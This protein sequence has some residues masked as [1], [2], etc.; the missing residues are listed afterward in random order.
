M[1]DVIADIKFVV[2]L[3]DP[4]AERFE[5]ATVLGTD[6]A[7][8]VAPFPV[9]VHDVR[10]RLGTSEA[11]TLD[12]DGYAAEVMPYPE[13]NSGEE[14]WEDEYS[15]AMATWLQDYL[16]ARKVVWYNYHVRRRIPEDDPDH[17][18]EFNKDKL[19]PATVAHVDGSQKVAFERACKFLELTE[20]EGRKERL[21]VINLWRPLVGPV[22]DFPL[23]LCDTRTARLAD[24]EITTDVYGEGSF[25]RYSPKHSFHYL[26]DQMPD[27]MLLLRCFDSTRSPDQSGV[28]I[29]TAFEDKARSGP[30]FPCRQSIEIRCCV[31]Y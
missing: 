10:P 26:R 15:K 31:L 23:A 2:P 29:H 8:R 28:T 21:A 20:K 5:F 25:S 7:L 6:E 17:P 4:R 24:L 11:P 14:G 1:T 9:T 30:G 19:Q 13:L 16:G 27:E 22:G 3:D 12:V 18:K